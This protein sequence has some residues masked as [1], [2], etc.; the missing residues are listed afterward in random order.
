MRNL[1]EI[2][3][4]P[5]DADQATIRKSFKQLARRYHPD[6]SEEKDAETRFKEINAAYEV[7][8]DEQ[9]RSWY[10]EFGEESLKVGF[11]A[12]RARMYRRAGVGAGGGLGFDQGFGGGGVSLDELFGNMFGRGGGRRRGWDESVTVRRRGADVEVR[13]E[14]DLLTA[15]R[16]GESLIE[17]RRPEA[18]P[19]CKGEG[20]TGK[21]ACPACRGTGRVTQSRFGMQA[22]VLCDQCA[23][24]GST[25]AQ[26]CSTCAGSGRTT[27]LRRL[28]V[29]IPTG[30]QD[31]QSL[32]LR[33][34]GGEGRNGGPPGNLMVTVA[35]KAHPL[36]RREG[37]DLELDLPITIGEALAGAT[38]TVPTPDGELKLRIPSG[39]RNGQQLRLKGR[40][41]AKPD[42]SRGHLYLVL[43]P[44]LPQSDEPA[45]LELAAQLDAFLDGDVRQGLEL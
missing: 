9:R 7:L 12:E 27:S 10:D 30:V 42:G 24:S 1:Y 20:G 13:A 28:K 35:V 43:R 22:V 6:V 39:A 18:C 33:G 36:L 19:S 31:G 34:L 3:S 14:I 26:E 5:K 41:V 17:I 21:Q 37:D 29:H 15:V 25:F 16:G 44:V 23:G 38:V 2:L 45:A 32:R 4:V 11:D 8:K 40:G